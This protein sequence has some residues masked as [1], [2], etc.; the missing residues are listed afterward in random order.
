MKIWLSGIYEF[1]LRYKNIWAEVWKIRKELDHP[2]RKKD[3][4]EFLPAHL[5]LIETPV[6]KKPRLIAYLIMLFLVV[7]I[8]LASVSKVEIVATAPGKLTFSGRS[9]EIKP[10]ENAI[11]Q[12]IFVKDGQFV[13]KGQLLVSLTALGSD[14][15]IK[16]TMASLSLAKLENYR[17]QT[18]LTAIEKESFAGD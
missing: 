17:Y 9:K 18:L 10:I 14:A 11:V 15:D 6:S 1:F 13:E 8:V 2:N 4:S 12:E 7:A 5:E 3:E 16:K